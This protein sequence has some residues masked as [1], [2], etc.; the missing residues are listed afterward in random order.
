MIS[1]LDSDFS[2]LNQFLEKTKPSQIII[3]VDENT[4]EYCL[5]TLLGNLQTDIHFEIVEIEAGEENKNISTAIQIWEILSD[6]KVDRKSLLIN[7]GGG[8]ISDLGGFIASTYKRGFSFINLPTTLLSMCDASIGGKTGIDHQ[9]LKN[10]VGTFALPEQIFVYTDFLKT[11]PFIELRSGFA[12]MLKHGL[13]ADRQHWSTLSSI[14]ELTP[15]SIA[16]FIETSMKI[17]QEVV[18][19]DFKE[20]NVRKTLNFGHTIGHAV[21]SLFMAL[22]KPIPH[23]EAVALGMI[24]ESY[25]ALTEGLIDNE[26]YHN[27][28]K[29]LLRFYPYISIKELSNENIITL[30][31]N[32]KKNQ[33]GIV[34]FALINGIGSCL[35]DYKVDEK[36]VISALDYYRNLEK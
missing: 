29:Q 17:K 18:N 34:N 24:T 27:I 12:E 2:S 14:T 4:H 3:L 31:K 5:P 36:Q 32:D 23:G 19:R 15:E 9:Y 6:F 1:R 7:L 22:E 21:E 16:P 30:M 35:F 33:N 25:L 13:I 20:Q 11:L 8:V 26:T 28:E 10:I